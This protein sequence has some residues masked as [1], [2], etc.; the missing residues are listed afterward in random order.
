MAAERLGARPPEGA[1]EP[2]WPEEA[3]GI[4][5]AV[6]ARRAEFHLGRALARRVLVELGRPPCA[7][8]VRAGR[9]PL[10][11]A[12]VVGSISH[13]AGLCL[14]AVAEK[15]DVTALGIDVEIAAPFEAKLMRRVASPCELEAFSRVNACSGPEAAA[16]LFSAKESVYK[17]QHPISGAFLEFQD[18]AV[19]ASAP[20]RFRA[21]LLPPAARGALGEARLEGSWHRVG[22]WLATLCTLEPP[23]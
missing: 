23:Q 1:L 19:E 18:V 20:E 14:V 12:G 4:H 10:W 5:G 3:L 15:N 21:H 7:I 16:I 11:P 17:A 9:A 2:S 8:P 22:P 6:P 13:G